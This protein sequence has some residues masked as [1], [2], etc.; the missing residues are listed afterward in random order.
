MTGSQR[1]NR[2]DQVEVDVFSDRLELMDPLPIG[3]RDCQSL[4]LSPCAIFVTYAVERLNVIEILV[5]YTDFPAKPLDVTV[6][7]PII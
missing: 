6:N 4:R 5:M 3:A 7:C 2:H 1:R